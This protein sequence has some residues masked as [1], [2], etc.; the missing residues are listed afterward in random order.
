MK[1]NLFIATYYNNEKFIDL[2][3]KT[4]K[5]YIKDDFDYV[6]VNDS[7]IDTKSIYSNKLA[8][9][10]IEEESTAQKV[11]HLRVPQEIHRNISSGGLVPDGLPANHPT[12]RHRA[13]L[14]WILKSGDLINFNDYKYV[15]ITESDLFIKSDINISN[16]M[17]DYDLIGPGRKN[18]HLKRRRNDPN[19]VWAEKYNHLDEVTID[20]FAMYMLFFNSEKIKN[21]H[22]MDI[23]GF[24]GTDTGGKTSLFLKENPQYKHLILDVHTSN[25]DQIDVFSKPNEKL[26]D[27]KFVHFRAGSNWDQQSIEYYREKLRRLFDKNIPSIDTGI[28][29]N[30]KPLT[31][32][33][34]QHIFLPNNQAKIVK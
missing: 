18:V 2:Q 23:G 24:A 20:F 15:V 22:E 16:F 5:K 25:L 14:Y 17:E 10:A 26:E 9:K 11:R 31:S 12:E 32:K 34:K 33:D 13:T 30:D 4:F 7:D 21:I 27:G 8:S 3:L 19:Q 6:V 1:K 28:K 29:P